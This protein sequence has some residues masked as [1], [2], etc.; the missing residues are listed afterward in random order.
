ML[1]RNEYGGKY[2]ALTEKSTTGD[3][4]FGNAYI[5][6]RVIISGV[7]K[8]RPRKR[9]R[10][11]CSTGTHGYVFFLRNKKNIYIFLLFLNSD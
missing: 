8:M 11:F 7:R 9:P 3:D 6:T 5:Y 4:L 10:L 1:G 2:Y